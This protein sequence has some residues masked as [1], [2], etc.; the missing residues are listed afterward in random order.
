VLLTHYH[1]D[2]INN[3]ATEGGP[4]SVFET[5]RKSSGIE[6]IWQVHLALNTPQGVNTDERMIANMGPTAECKGEM[7]KA[8]VDSRGQFTM[9]N[10]RNGF[11]KTYQ[12]KSNII[13]AVASRGVTSA[14][15]A[16]AAGTKRAWWCLA[17]RN[18]QIPQAR[19]GR[20]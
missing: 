15:H 1:G 18:P 4:I 19:T 20:I 9:T 5:L 7:L 3:G 17:F 14:I 2:H 6:D 12:S 13:R 11:S 8:S 10:L 16:R